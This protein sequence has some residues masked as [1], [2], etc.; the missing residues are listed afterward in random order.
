MNSP[1][2]V[3]RRWVALHV[4]ANVVA[5][6]CLGWGALRSSGLVAAGLGAALGVLLGEGLA[7]SRLRSSVLALGLLLG[8][9]VV[10]ALSKALLWSAWFP[11]MLGPVTALTAGTV[12]RY[13]ALGAGLAATLRTLSVRRPLFLGLELAALAY[14][15]ASLFSGHRDGVVARPLWLGDWAWRQG[16]DPTEVLLWLGG[17]VALFLVLSLLGEGQRRAQSRATLA[18]WALLP[19]AALLAVWLSHKIGLPTPKTKDNLG[20]LKGEEGAGGEKAEAPENK[21]PRPG[22]QGEKKPFDPAEQLGQNDTPPVPKTPELGPDGQP[23]KPQESPEGRPENPRDPSESGTPQKPANQDPSG[24]PSEGKPSEGQPK[25]GQNKEGK[26]APKDQPPEKPPSVDDAPSEG[27]APRPAPVAVVVLGDDYQPP[28]QIFYLRQEA[29]S[30]FNGTRLV[31]TTRAG[32][33]QDG[34][35]R[36]PVQPENIADAPPRENRA[37]VRGTVSLLVEHNK[38]FALEAPV[39]F[40]P[41]ENPNPSRFVGAYR[42]ESLAQSTDY[43]ELFGKKAGD[44]RW[45]PEVRAFYTRAPS[46]LRYRAMAASIVATL[47]E[48]KQNDP[49]AKALAI[50]LFLDKNLIYSTAHRHAGV[51]DPTAD[52]LFGDKTGYCTHFAHAAVFLWRSQGIPARVGVGYAIPEEERQGSTLLIQ[53]NSAHAWP[54][55]YLDGVGWFPLDISPEKNLDPPGEPIDR[56]LQQLLGEM[57]RKEPPP[58]EHA[59]RSSFQWRALWAALKQLAEWLLYASVLGLYGAKLWRAWVPRFSSAEDLARVGYRAGLDRLSELGASRHE[60]ETREDFARRLS[61][62]APTLAEMTR[63]HLAAR[64]GPSGRGPR[65]GDRAVWVQLAQ[66]LRRELAQSAPAWRRWLGFLN[67]LSFWWS[68]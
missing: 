56:D 65:G 26:D 53:N 45:S 31:P 36:F 44:A 14:A 19:L 54:E 49:F 12:L 22:E 42:F 57:A 18:T 25:D 30:E 48:D 4:L 43:R 35:L 50:K 21:A 28:S 63:L 2:P 9:Y 34:L 27:S 13:F 66:Q 47:P 16:I 17:G 37:L 40:A 64:L 39:L 67:P 20:L 8:A 7:A 38:P 32:I 33:D 68:R 15:L 62:R 6:L 11:A 3:A 60:G 55:L 1:A 61:A 41:M 10:G 59:G 24:K 29:W 51:D 23:V 46:D 52:F 58:G 5:A